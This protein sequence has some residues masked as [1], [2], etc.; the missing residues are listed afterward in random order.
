[1]AVCRVCGGE[2]LNHVSC[3]P[4][5]RI[6]GVVYDRIKFG[7]ESRY[8]KTEDEY[9]NDCGCKIGDYHHFECDIEEDPSD[10]GNQLLQRILFN[11][12][13]KIEVIE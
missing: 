9:C 5:L 3:Y 11:K 13:D 6:N 1:M 10:I 8:K 4:K 2:M 12:E 7:S